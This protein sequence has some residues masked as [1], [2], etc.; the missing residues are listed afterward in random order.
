ML[1]IADG[2]RVTIWKIEDKETYALVQFSS[3]RKDKTS[4]EYKNSSWSFVRF[5]GDAYKKI[6]ELQPKARIA[7]KGAGISIEPYVDK[8]GEK[9]YPKNPQIVVFNWDFVEANAET[10]DSAP[11]V[12]SSDDDDDDLPF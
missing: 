3:S 1:N 7:L 6:G 10:T 2:Q 12:K 8:N 5:V 9:K 11:V 4:G